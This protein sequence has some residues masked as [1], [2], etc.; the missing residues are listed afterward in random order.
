MVILF[1][2][3]H[4]Q[5]CTIDLIPGAVKVVKFITSDVSRVIISP[6]LI[7]RSDRGEGWKLVGAAEA[8]KG[9]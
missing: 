1:T 2:I 5:K 7:L 3:Y 6:T 9:T 4:S 8:N